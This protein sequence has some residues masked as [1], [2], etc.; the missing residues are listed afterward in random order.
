MG[1]AFSYTSVQEIL[2]KIFLLVVFMYIIATLTF[3]AAMGNY[4]MR[5]TFNSFMQQWVSMI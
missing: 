5:N 2:C 1:S 4:Y 3:M